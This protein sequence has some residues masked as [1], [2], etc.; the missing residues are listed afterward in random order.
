MFILQFDGNVLGHTLQ[1]DFFKIKLITILKLQRPN[2]LKEITTIMEKFLRTS[3]TTILK[4][5]FE[6]EKK[7]NIYAFILNI[8]LKIVLN[9]LTRSQQFYIT[10]SLK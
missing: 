1:E 4:R 5:I 8:L 10:I 2:D 6:I 7:V 3:L 9:F